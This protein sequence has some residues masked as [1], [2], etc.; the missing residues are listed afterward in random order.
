MDGRDPSRRIADNP[1]YVL[2]LRPE[3]SRAEVEREGQKL[4][5]ML[6]L[7]LS[8]ARTYDSPLGRR[9]RT[10]EKVREAMAELRD[11]DR[12]LAHEMWARYTVDVDADVDAAPDEG[13]APD[14]APE[15]RTPDGWVDAMTLLGWRRR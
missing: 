6:E 13:A 15:H 5:G 11:P 12:R 2:G 8:A 1:F 7:G 3:C 4:L 14:E 9:E 10:A